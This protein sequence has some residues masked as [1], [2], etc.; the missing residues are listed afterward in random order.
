MEIRSFPLPEKGVRI[1]SPFRRPGVPVNAVM[2][3]RRKPSLGA[4][5][6]VSAAAY[7]ADRLAGLDDVSDLD[8][9]L[10]ALQMRIVMISV[11]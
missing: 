10:V 6:A 8:P 9:F 11:I 1:E 5:R 3:M 7:P 2:K 4:G